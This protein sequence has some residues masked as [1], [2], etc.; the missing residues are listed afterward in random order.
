MLMSSSIVTLSN[1]LNSKFFSDKLFA[2]SQ[3]STQLQISTE[4]DRTAESN[5]ELGSY[6]AQETRA[7]ERM[8]SRK[9]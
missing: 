7:A 3:E 8:R 2:T 6:R 9:S 5:V 1:F 4:Q